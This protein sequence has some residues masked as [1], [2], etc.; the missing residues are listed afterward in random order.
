MVNQGIH[1]PYEKSS[2]MS[3]FQDWVSRLR[4]ENDP[5]HHDSSSRL[6]LVLKNDDADHIDIKFQLP[7]VTTGFNLKPH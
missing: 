4:L 3:T 1:K 6:V 7:G 2:L 5:V